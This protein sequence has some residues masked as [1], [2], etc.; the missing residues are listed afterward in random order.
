MGPD[1]SAVNKLKAEVQMKIG[2]R[3]LTALTTLCLLITCGSSSTSVAATVHA[4]SATAVYQADWTGGTA[5]WEVGGAGRWTA[6]GDVLRASA[7]SDH[8][9]SMFLAPVQ[10]RTGTF[11]VTARLRLV[12]WTG[13]STNEYG[14][15]VRSKGPR[16]PNDPTTAGLVG[17][18]VQLALDLGSEAAIYTFGGDSQRIYP[19]I[20][21]VT[22]PNKWHT[23]T[24]QVRGT[25]V[26]LLIDGG[27]A[28][29]VHVQ[30]ALGGRRVGLFVSGAAIQVKRFTVLSP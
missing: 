12:A 26:T 24:V 1:S 4:T 14:I 9:G 21:D 13:K 7:S 23:F 15:V 17:G 16:E 10:L 30:R 19:K 3:Y 28:T 11:S 6:S 2:R 27:E 18:A 22:R 29:H 5:G 25:R 8:G 20:T